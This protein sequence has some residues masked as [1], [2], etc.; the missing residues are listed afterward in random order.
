[1]KTSR[2]YTVF[3]VVAVLAIA[4]YSISGMKFSNNYPVQIEKERKEKDEMFKNSD[5]SPLTAA[6]KANFDSLT[7]YPVDEKHKIK[8]SFILNDKK[9]KLELAY[10]DGS[11]KTYLKYGY[12]K[13]ELNGIPQQVTI[14]KPTF[15]VDE[16]YL[17]L[18]FYDE[19][20]ALET[21]GGGR[22]LDL[23]PNPDDIIEL[24]FNKAYNPYCAYNH[25]YRCPIPPK[26]NRI[27]VAV[28]AG[29]KNFEAAE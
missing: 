16:A 13:F 11:T 5:E 21:Y 4:V 6:Q 23:D 12:A 27:S 17:F 26:E 7:Y 15:F 25:E 22:Y 24:D 1:M 20:S 9:E 2:I 29:E 8:A 19:T 28:T 3:I 18:P 10:T 14:L